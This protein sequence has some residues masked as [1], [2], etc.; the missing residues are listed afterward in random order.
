[1]SVIGRVGSNFQS[2]AFLDSSGWAEPPARAAAHAAD[3]TVASMVA[4]GQGLDLIALCVGLDREEVL[5][6]VVALDL[7][8]PPDRPLRP[9]IA[10]RGWLLDLYPLLADLWVRGFR[11]RVIGGV[12]GRSPGAVA[13]KARRLGLP[14]RPRASLLP[15]DASPGVIALA[16]VPPVSP[17]A[18]PDPAVPEAI[19]ALPVAVSSA[20][21]VEASPTTA[22]SP[23]APS[24]PPAPVL[25]QE[26]PCAAESPSRGESPFQVEW[27]PALEDELADRYWANQLPAS[28]ARDMGVSFRAVTSKLHRLELPLRCRADLVDHYDP[29]AAK[30]NLAASGYVKRRCKYWSERTRSRFKDRWFWAPRNGPRVS[31]QAKRLASFQA[32]L[33][34]MGGLYA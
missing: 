29:E 33:N 34:S 9:P 26:H 25:P 22:P 31:R 18:D 17:A 23:L 4:S 30:A 3:R 20:P 12:V 10:G 8:T 19:P 5:D 24:A 2:T 27:T 1:M 14:R 32:V 11:S 6:R 13:S 16:A 7:P 28:M 21:Q 15:F